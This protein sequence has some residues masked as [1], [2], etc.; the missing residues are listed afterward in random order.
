MRS[1]P[2]QNLVPGEPVIWLV[3]LWTRDNYSWVDSVHDNIDSVR[4]RTEE[5]CKEVRDGKHPYLKH[6][7]V[8]KYPLNR[9]AEWIDDGIN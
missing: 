6:G 7:G 9:P 3:K 4:K 5:I 2:A 8:N 1:L